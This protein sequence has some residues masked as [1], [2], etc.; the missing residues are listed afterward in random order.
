[1][2]ARKPWRRLRLTTLGW[3]VLFMLITDLEAAKGAGIYLLNLKIVNIFL[4]F[5]RFLRKL[6]IRFFSKYLVDKINLSD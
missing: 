3:K 5:L 4:V 1:M 6:W 2:R